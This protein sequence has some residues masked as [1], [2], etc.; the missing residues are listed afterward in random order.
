ADQRVGVVLKGHEGVVGAVDFDEPSLGVVVVG[1]GSEVRDDARDQQAGG[2]GVVGGDGAV[3]GIGDGGDAVIAV[4][5]RSDG[6]AVAIDDRFEPAA[7]VIEGALGAV[8][9]GDGPGGG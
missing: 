8:L 9:E 2:V 3:G 5:A 7:V 1:E 4:V 6:V